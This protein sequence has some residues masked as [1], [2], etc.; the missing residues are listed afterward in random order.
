MEDCTNL[1]LNFLHS[2]QYPQI[3]EEAEA[4][5]D[6]TVVQR[7]PEGGPE[8]AVDTDV[9]VHPGANR[10]GKRAPPIHHSIENIELLVEKTLD[11]LKSSGPCPKLSVNDA[12]AMKEY[13]ILLGHVVLDLLRGDQLRH[14]L[15]GEN[16]EMVEAPLDLFSKAAQLDEG[17]VTIRGDMVADVASGAAVCSLVGLVVA[18][19]SSILYGQWEVSEIIGLRGVG[20]P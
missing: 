9:T 8:A 15:G 5:D 1:V 10:V 14:L 3:F 12:R 2:M 7:V 16:V 17:E 18:G 6:V 13:A 4:V 19:V 20:G 11:V